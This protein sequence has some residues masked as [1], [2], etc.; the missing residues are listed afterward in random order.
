MTIL[1][2][3]EKEDILLQGGDGKEVKYIPV[4]HNEK[5]VYDA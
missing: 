1:E 4:V 2:N 3:E 5:L